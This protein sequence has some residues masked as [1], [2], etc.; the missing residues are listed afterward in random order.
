MFLGTGES[1]LSIS[2]ER[3]GVFVKLATTYVEGFRQ[4]GGG[5]QRVGGMCS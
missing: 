1:N 4:R 5:A 3:L 2:Y